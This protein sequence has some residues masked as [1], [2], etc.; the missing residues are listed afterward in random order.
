MVWNISKNGMLFLNSETRTIVVHLNPR[1]AKGEGALEKVTTYS[2]ALLV[3]MGS[4]DCLTTVVGMRYF[5]AVELNPLMS[6][7]ASTSLSAFV[8]LKLSA[9]VF[10]CIVLIQAEKILM[11]TT[12]QT[13]KTF[14]WTKRF[15]KIAT[16]SVIAFLIIVVANN[17]WVL[18]IAH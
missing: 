16:A 7:V 15:L 9:T 13:T 12:N 2:W 3:L 18:L 5:G 4:L 17:I 11:K 10:A 14:A 1:D 6:S 8:V